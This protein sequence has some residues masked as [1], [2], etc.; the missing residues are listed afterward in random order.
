MRAPHH[1]GTGGLLQ[2][3]LDLFVARL[4]ELVGA[5][6]NQGSLRGG[7]L[8]VTLEIVGHRSSRAFPPATRDRGNGHG[9]QR[10][11][12]ERTHMSS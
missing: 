8:Q 6:L 2:F 10:Q 7:Q 4:A 3:Q 12:G 5:D 11:S 1:L 9:S